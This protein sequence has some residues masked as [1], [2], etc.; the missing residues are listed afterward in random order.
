MQAFKIIGLMS[1]WSFTKQQYFLTL[2][3][4]LHLQLRCISLTANKGRSNCTRKLLQYTV[5]SISRTVSEMLLIEIDQ[6]ENIRKSLTSG[7][8]R[9]YEYF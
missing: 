8:K 6:L 2:H 5:Q 7:E 3:Y 9:P 1:L 4:P